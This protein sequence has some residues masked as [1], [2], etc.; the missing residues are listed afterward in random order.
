MLNDESDV[1]ETKFGM[2]ELVCLTDDKVTCTDVSA[3]VVRII[4][5][6]DASDALMTKM[7]NLIEHSTLN[8]VPFQQYGSEGTKRH[9]LYLRNMALKALVNILSVVF[10]NRTDPSISDK[11]HECGWIQIK[12][13]V[14]ILVKELSCAKANP[15]NAYLSAKC[16]TS[17]V[18]S[19]IL[20]K[21]LAKEINGE[22]AA[23]RSL[24][25]GKASHALL[26][27]E[28]KRVAASLHA[29]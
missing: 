27:E 6:D 13:I 19:S 20:A 8:G 1:D 15:H 29:V 5:C 11:G 4:F 24:A 2:E 12:S 14:P 21:K 9:S 16:I 26:E 28:S 17:L 18:S 7:L 22:D 3:E 25:V 23:Q 10:Q